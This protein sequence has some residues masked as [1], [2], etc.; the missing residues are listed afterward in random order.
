[1]GIV[2]HA[3]GYKLVNKKQADVSTDMFK[4]VLA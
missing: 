3:A 4:A 2:F 1:M